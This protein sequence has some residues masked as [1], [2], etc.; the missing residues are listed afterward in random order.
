MPDLHPFPQEG[1]DDHHPLFK[2]ISESVHLSN[3]AYA[4]DAIIIQLQGIPDK[5]PAQSGG[6]GDD[7]TWAFSITFPWQE[8]SFTVFDKQPSLVQ[9]LTSIHKFLKSMGVEL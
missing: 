5:V 1:T 8:Q 3:P 2:L 9:A 6:G 7:R 4:K